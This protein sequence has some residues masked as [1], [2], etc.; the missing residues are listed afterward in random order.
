M[1]CP[2]IGFAGNIERVI[3]HLVLSVVNSITELESL[4]M[5]SPLDA[6]KSSTLLRT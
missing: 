6:S 1:D 2:S 5:V 3:H 4:R